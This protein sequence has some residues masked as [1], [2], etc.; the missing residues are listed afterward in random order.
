MK[1]AV[2]ACVF[3]IAAAACG[4]G[5]GGGGSKGGAGTP[6]E[7]GKVVYAL[8]AATTNFCLPRAQLAIPGIMVAQSMYDTLT[9][10]DASGKFV[11]YL[12]KSVTHNATY[13]EWT[14]TLRDGIK[15]H[16]GELL[17]ANAVA[18]NINAW[19]SGL[20]LQF[21]F[22][23]ISDVVVQDP[24]TVVVKLKQPW[25]D[26]AG[27]LWATGRTGIAAPRQLDDDATCPTNMI[28]TGPFMKKSFDPV[29]GEVDVVKNP[30][31]WR[32]DSAGRQ[33]PYLNELDFKIQT[34]GA[35]R[36]NGLQGGQ[37]D[38]IQ[39]DSGVNLS[40]LRSLGSAVTINM[41]PRGRQEL[42]HTLINV[43]RPPF[44][45]MN[46]RIALAEGTDD[47]ALNQINNKGLFR[48]AKG[49][50][51]TGTQ[52]Y[53][54]DPGYPK[55][56]Q[57]DARQKVA[58]YKAAHGGKMQFDLQTTPDAVTQALAQEIVRQ[59]AQIGVTVNLPRPIDQ[60]TIINQAIGGS[61]DAFI[62]RNYPGIG[63]DSM[64]VWFH[65][66][67]PVN[68]NHVSDAQLDKD[69]DQGRVEADPAKAAA[70]YQDFDRRM[71]SQV[72]NLWGWYEQWFVGTKPSVHGVFGPNLPDPTGKPGADKPVPMVAGYHQLLGIW[73]S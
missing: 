30:N 14:I 44:N 68:F 46:A 37:F 52:G 47:N 12:A 41:E 19:R 5:G 43:T 67:S 51:D 8:E 11:P 45:D 17:D 25:V 23:P 62:W 3:M 2:T 33:L 66:K 54:A 48:T 49:V 6:K 13:D 24:M 70:L 16:D 53:V 7:G 36:V 64:Y 28:G 4:G 20:L 73:V 10:P 38:A 15:F 39:D 59:M 32:K 60:P 9:E 55:Y 57:A 61:V 27:Y 40:S 50:F 18:K 22:G 21:V 71:S 63:G 35:Q 69:L 1:L 42:G 34:E 29:G 58:A 72:Y 26:F 31:Y 56:N 65:S